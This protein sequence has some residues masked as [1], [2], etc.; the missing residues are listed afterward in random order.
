MVGLTNA[1]PD[2]FQYSDQSIA[3]DVVSCQCYTNLGSLD[4]RTA[5][6]YQEPKC[7][8]RKPQGSYS[9]YAVTI[10]IS[11]SINHDLTCF[12]PE[13]T[14]PNMANFHAQLKLITIGSFPYYVTETGA[15]YGGY[16]KIKTNLVYPNSVATIATGMTVTETPSAYPGP[17]KYVNDL[18]TGSYKITVNFASV[19]S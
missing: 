17:L 10:G 18:L 1:Y 13:F 3:N 6:S 19:G 15:G 2:P 16:N 11:A 4:L 14:V 8:R 12:F 7:V 9:N 5:V